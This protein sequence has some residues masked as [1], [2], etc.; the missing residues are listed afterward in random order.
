MG[1]DG[2]GV[3]VAF[4]AAEETKIAEASSDSLAVGARVPEVSMPEYRGTSAVSQSSASRSF[5]HGEV[6]CRSGGRV[7]RTQAEA[8]S[9]FCRSG[10][11]DG[12]RIR[13]EAGSATCLS[14][15][16]IQSDAGKGDR[17]GRTQAE[18]GCSTCRS[19]VGDGQN[20]HRLKR[21]GSI[22][23]HCSSCVL[24]H[25]K[26]MYCSQC[27]RV[28]RGPS[29]LGDPTLWL[30][31]S[32]CHRLSH[33]DC[34]RNQGFSTDSFFFIC[35]YCHK[36]TETEGQDG[37]PAL[38]KLRLSTS[39]QDSPSLSDQETLAAAQIVA[40]L[41]A[42]EAKEAKVRAR[43]SAAVAVKASNLAKA[44]LDAAYKAG[45]EEVRWRLEVSKHTFAVGA[46][47]QD[48]RTVN[49][50]ANILD[51][52]KQEITVGLE[53][54]P[55]YMPY[56]PPNEGDL[57]K[58]PGVLGGPGNSRAAATLL[59][60]HKRRLLPPVVAPDL[61][62]TP[63]QH[64]IALQQQ[65][66]PPTQKD[67]SL[68]SLQEEQHL[69]TV[70]Q[71]IVVSAS[72]ESILEGSSLLGTPR[73][74]PST[75]PAHPEVGLSRRDAIGSS[76]CCRV[77]LGEDSHGTCQVTVLESDSV[78]PHG[79]HLSA[80]GRIS[81]SCSLTGTPNI[82]SLVLAGKPIHD[83]GDKVVEILPPSIDEETVYDLVCVGD[84]L[85]DELKK[86]RNL[87]SGLVEVEGDPH[88][89]GISVGD[90]LS[91]RTGS[92]LPRKPENDAGLRVPSRSTSEE[93][94]HTGQP[95]GT[96]NVR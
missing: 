32:K 67:G 77:L 68:P 74:G 12:G 13:A 7:D 79:G 65:Q 89:T 59:S 15:G 35:H 78:V 23:L 24:Y 39:Q 75:L 27:F 9:G 93:T 45:Q 58:H 60:H 38:K 90:S 87:S 51:M 94:S 52:R 41:A 85:S 33:L 30:T 11:G 40:A 1:D 2:H 43:A 70:P 63:V 26:G 66:P 54:H 5:N 86:E 37:S 53:D 25:H 20:L 95:R 91:E 96:K 36:E 81:M 22:C 29:Q 3:E 62:R 28:H 61:T 46:T 83:V 80:D 64:G 56:M 16:R 57:G 4:S 47:A 71:G 10:G 44:A 72:P 82:N 34:A 92:M 55:R 73:S 84:L 49:T 42:N 69:A 50:G 48:A 8:G 88:V 6:T 14:G 31:C 17:N 19:A 21:D 76:L 18:I